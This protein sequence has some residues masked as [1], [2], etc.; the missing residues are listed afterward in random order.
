MRGSSFPARCTLG[1]VDAWNVHAPSG[2]RRLRRF[3]ASYAPENRFYPEPQRL[4]VAGAVIDPAFQGLVPSDVYLQAGA[5]FNEVVK[6]SLVAVKVA[7]DSKL[8]TRH[9]TQRISLRIHHPGT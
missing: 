6:P 5:V 2:K 8:P 9:N 7:S 4:T 3:P 1:N